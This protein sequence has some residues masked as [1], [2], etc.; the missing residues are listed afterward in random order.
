[1]TDPY[2]VLGVS[3][4]ASQDEIKKAYRKLALKYHPDRNNGSKEAEEKMKEINEAYAMLTDPNYKPNNAAHSG[5]GSGGYGNPYGSWDP[6]GGFG[7]GHGGYQRAY[8]DEPS[9]IKAARNYVMNGYYQEALNVLNQ[10]AA[11]TAEWYFLSAQANVGMGNRVIARE[12]ARQAVGMDPDN[13]EYRMLLQQI[14]AGGETYRARGRQFGMPAALCG[15]PC[16]TC[17]ALNCLCN[18]CCGGMRFL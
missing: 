18:C 1:M 16:V 13:F 4:D 8:N 5:G 17:I 6:F 14:E 2:Q 12:H 7:G 11:R 15:N 9:E 3:H 10:T